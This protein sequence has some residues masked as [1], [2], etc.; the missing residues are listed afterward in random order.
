MGI[1]EH[2]PFQLPIPLLHATI[3][4]QASIL[5]VLSHN[6]QLHPQSAASVCP[7]GTL[8]RWKLEPT[9]PANLRRSLPSGNQAWQ[10]KMDNL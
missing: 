2:G 8:V 4:T 9:L 7:M 6:T 5:V 1:V 10:W 3:S